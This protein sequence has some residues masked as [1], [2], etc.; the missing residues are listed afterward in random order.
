MPAPGEDELL[1]TLKGKS[2]FHTGRLDDNPWGQL[3]EAL[4]GGY[5]R[6]DWIWP[7]RAPGKT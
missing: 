1:A 7:G 5:E 4:R 6:R 2:R 3:V